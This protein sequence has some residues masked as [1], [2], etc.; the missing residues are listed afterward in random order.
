MDCPKCAGQL[1]IEDDERY[2]GE[3]GVYVVMCYDCAWCDK[4][5][6]ISYDEA[7]DRLDALEALPPSPLQFGEN[8]KLTIDNKLEV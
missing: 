3:D 8:E 4:W 1:Y 5:A 6:Y 7:S 2:S